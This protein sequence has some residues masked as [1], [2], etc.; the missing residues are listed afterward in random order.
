MSNDNGTQIEE[1]LAAIQSKLKK[2]NKMVAD[3]ETEAKQIE[4]RT[5]RVLQTIRKTREQ[6]HGERE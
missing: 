2:L 3:I 4:E 6:L 1:K 5:E